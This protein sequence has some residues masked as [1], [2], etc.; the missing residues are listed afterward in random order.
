M[1]LGERVSCLEF[2]D[3]HRVRSRPPASQRTSARRH[4]CRSG[5]G[6]GAGGPNRMGDGPHSLDQAHPLSETNC[7]GKRALCD[8]R[9]E[10]SPALQAPHVLSTRHTDDR[11]H[12][13]VD[14]QLLGAADVLLMAHSQLP[15]LIAAPDLQLL[16][17]RDSAAVRASAPTRRSGRR[18]NTRGAMA[19]A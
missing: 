17:W 9:T 18:H 8:R 1:S 3:P 16:P 5:P 19:P 6:V 4:G 11:G 12:C 13:A 2:A 7:S 14:G 10:Q 15:V